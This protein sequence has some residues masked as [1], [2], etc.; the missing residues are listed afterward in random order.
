MK[1]T[2][3]SMVCL[4]DERIADALLQMINTLLFVRS[5]EELRKG[6][7]ELK[8]KY[9]ID[10]LFAYGYGKHHLWVHQRLVSDPQ[11][12]LENRLLIVEF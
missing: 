4:W 10:E 12:Y 2:I 9:P 3:E 1:V 8:T 5:E 6:M 7:E 11:K